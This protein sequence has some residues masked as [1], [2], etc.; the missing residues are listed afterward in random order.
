M[1]SIVTVPETLAFEDTVT[2]IKPR[3]EE[4]STEAAAA[5]VSVQGFSV[6]NNPE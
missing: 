1:P 4:G 6:D 5:P 3:T 2:R